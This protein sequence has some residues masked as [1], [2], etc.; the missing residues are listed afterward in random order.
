M[1]RTS[2]TVLVAAVAGVLSVS[3][4]SCST[5]GDSGSDTSSASSSGSSAGGSSAPKQTTV[6][7]VTHDSFVAP[8]ELLAQFTKETGYQVQVLASGDAGKLANSVVLAKGNPTGDVVFGIDN[9]F[10]SRVVDA[11]ALTPYTSAKLPQGADK[12]ALTGEAAKSLTPIDFGDVCVNVDDAWFAAHK[13]AKPNSLDDLTKPE[14]KDLFVTPGAATSS[15][16][17]AFLLATIA[18]YGDNG[19]QDY[20]KKL[21][22]NGVKVTSGW[23]DAWSVDYTAGGGKGSRPIVLSY[24]TSPADTVK[25]GKATTSAMTDSCFRQVEY[26]GVLKGAKNEP[27]AQAFIDFLLGKTFQ[28]SMPANMYVFPV[29]PAVAIP[30]QWKAAVTV[31]DKT[32]KVDPAKITANRDKWLREWQDT[33]SG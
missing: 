8:K 14:Y 25:D 17:M 2:R 5:T 10:A 21:K 30:A 13:K 28:A 23:S 29:D 20:W 11:G 27:G 33:V 16:G 32:L 1:F 6:R 19:W 24:N 22:A 7:L 18:K 9:T 3:L 26:A 31:P 15:P 4:A 12:Y